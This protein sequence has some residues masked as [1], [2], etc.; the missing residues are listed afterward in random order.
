MTILP[1]RWWLWRFIRL[2]SA[3]TFSHDAE[4]DL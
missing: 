1:D 3:V 2:Y 4:G